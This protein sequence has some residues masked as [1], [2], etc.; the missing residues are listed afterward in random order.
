MTVAFT[1]SARG[2]AARG[3][4]AACGLLLLAGCDVFEFASNALPKEDAFGCY[5]NGD[6]GRITVSESG[7]AY[8][9]ESWF[10]GF[11]HSKGD[12]EQHSFIIGRP[13]YAFRAD[14]NRLTERV[15]KSGDSARHYLP[16]D[17]SEAQPTLTVELSD[18]ER[19]LLSFSLADCATP[20]PR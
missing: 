6:F 12:D 14:G 8:G 11:T 2:G 20:P 13:H 19:T 3:T 1:H 16:L 15:V 4:I 18:A 5:D 7:V 17:R 10:G 9:A